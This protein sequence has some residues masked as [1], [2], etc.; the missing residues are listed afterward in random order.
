MN[1]ITK[2]AL[3]LV[4]AL[5]AGYGVYTSQQKSELSE[6]ALANIEALADNEGPVKI[7]CVDERD[8]ECKFLTEGADGIWRHIV[9]KDMRKSN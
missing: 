7:P 3:A 5:T 2:T 1:R 4:V 9:I 6:L 8:S